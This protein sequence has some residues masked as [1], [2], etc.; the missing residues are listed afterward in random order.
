MKKDCVLIFVQFECHISEVPRA[1]MQNGKVVW[2]NLGKILPS[3]PQ[4]PH[5]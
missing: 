4:V 3:M 2:Y 1:Q 5:A